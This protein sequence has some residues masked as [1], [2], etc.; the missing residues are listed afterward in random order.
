M[1]RGRRRSRAL[2]G[3]DWGGRIMSVRVNG[4]GTPWCHRDIVEVAA[5]CP[6]LDRIV[7]P[8]SCEA[9]DIRFVATLLDGVEQARGGGRP[10]GIAAL[11]ETAEGRRPGGGDRRG[12]SAAGDA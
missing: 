5:A 12:A 7:L 4:I 3:V 1:R 10:I 9:F 6:R 8:K 2:N 11:V